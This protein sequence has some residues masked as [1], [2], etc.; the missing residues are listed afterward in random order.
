VT[1]HCLYEGGSVA[2]IVEEIIP[3]FNSSFV[4][5]QAMPPI[6]MYRWSFQLENI[7]PNLKLSA[8]L[9]LVLSQ[10][11]SGYVPPLYSY[12]I[13]IYFI[14]VLI[15]F[16]LH[17]LQAVILEDCPSFPTVIIPLKSSGNIMYSNFFK[18]TI[19]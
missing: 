11:M 8:Y 6:N 2:I 12:Y 5:C 10:G 18:S 13:D 1:S 15:Q 4:I 19:N 3:L 17:H 16:G 14:V 7:H 9:H